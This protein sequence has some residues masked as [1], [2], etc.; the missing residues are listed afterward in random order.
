MTWP[1]GRG[2][3]GLGENLWARN[4]LRPILPLVPSRCTVVRDA[5][6]QA[7]GWA[8]EASLPVLAGSELGGSEAMN[9]RVRF[10]WASEKVPTQMK[11]TAQG[12]VMMYPPWLMMPM[13]VYAAVTEAAEVAAAAEGAAL[14]AASLEPRIHL[15]LWAPPSATVVAAAHTRACERTVWGNGRREEVQGEVCS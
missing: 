8:G 13:G 15:T 5:S 1:S 6:S 12:W 2:H 4:I 10:F 3:G 9:W 7:L 14:G 11:L